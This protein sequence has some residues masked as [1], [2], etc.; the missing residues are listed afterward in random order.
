MAAGFS[1]LPAVQCFELICFKDEDWRYSLSRYTLPQ[2]SL[3]SGV[4]VAITLFG[5]SLGFWPVLP[6][7]KLSS[8]LLLFRKCLSSQACRL[9][10]LNTNI[11]A[12]FATSAFSPAAGPANKMENEV[13]RLWCWWHLHVPQRV[14]AENPLGKVCRHSSALGICVFLG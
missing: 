12:H 5:F 2:W 9:V 7:V 10:Q 13:R 4:N 8:L 3:V 1:W 11:V 6:T 14:A